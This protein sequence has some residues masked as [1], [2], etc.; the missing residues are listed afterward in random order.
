MDEEAV[1]SVGIGVSFFCWIAATKVGDVISL[2][3]NT[4]FLLFPKLSL[5]L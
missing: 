1:E 5:V 3:S 2:A 4:I